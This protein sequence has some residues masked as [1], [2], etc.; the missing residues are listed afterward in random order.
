MAE[1]LPV[2]RDNAI[3][4]PAALYPTSRERETLTPSAD[5]AGCEGL[6]IVGS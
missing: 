6:L 1:S 2:A 4:E 5:I 3:N